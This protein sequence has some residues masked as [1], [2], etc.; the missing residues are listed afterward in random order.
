MTYQIV[1]LPIAGRELDKVPP[2]QFHLIDRVIRSF[3][4]SPRPA[5]I[6]K[7]DR[8]LYR[9]RVGHWRIVYTI[10]DREKRVVILRVKKRNERTYKGV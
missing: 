4:D 1:I 6:K 10:Q 5:G 8:D 9:V 7:L 2:D 3:S